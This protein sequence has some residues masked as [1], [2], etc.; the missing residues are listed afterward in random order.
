MD[1]ILVTREYHSPRCANDANPYES[2]CVQL[3]IDV[4]ESEAS[5]ITRVTIPTSDKSNVTGGTDYAPTVISLSTEE[6]GMSR[7]FTSAVDC[8]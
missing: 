1:R 5:E 7:S 2:S 8:R 4:S 3:F 6:Y